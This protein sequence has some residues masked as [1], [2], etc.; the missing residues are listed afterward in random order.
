MRMYLKNNSKKD[1]NYKKIKLAII[2]IIIFFIVFLMGKLINNISYTFME[3][4]KSK[5]LE[6]VNLRINSSIKEDVYN[7]LKEDIF[8]IN[9]NNNNEIEMI[10]YN[11]YKLN[12]LLDKVT[13][14]VQDEITDLTSDKKTF[15]IPFFSIFNNPLISN[16]GPDIPVRITLVNAIYSNCEIRIKE[17]GINNCLV[18][19][20][21]L[22]QIN[23]KV[24][25]PII[26]DNIVI[27]NEI[28]ISYKIINGKIP[29][30]YGDSI[31]KSS[32]IYTLP[33]D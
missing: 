29:Q 8:Y 25:L 30:Y 3:Y 4:T 21:V 32:N 20:Y 24:I 13:T 26:S 33:I 16:I 15:Y 18:E 1:I 12:L 9:K 28:P 23:I 10:D 14:S 19:I 22:L 31:S 7:D 27:E 17:F 6:M 2:L 11:T 5:A